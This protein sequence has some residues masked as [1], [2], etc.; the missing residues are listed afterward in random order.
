MLIIE[1]LRSVPLA[2]IL[3]AVFISGKNG[4]KKYGHF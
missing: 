1:I 2:K 3:S 4:N